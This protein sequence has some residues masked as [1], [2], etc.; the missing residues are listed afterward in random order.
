MTWI[1]QNNLCSPNQERYLLASLAGSH[2]YAL[3]LSFSLPP[4]VDATRL[5]SIA[6]AT[7]GKIPG[8]VVRFESVDLGRFTWR[9]DPS[10]GPAIRRQ[11]APDVATAT[12]DAAAFVHGGK[13]PARG[14]A[15]CKLHLAALE[16]GSHVLTVSLH[17]AVA[18]AVS[19]GLVIDSISQAW[20]TGQIAPPTGSEVSAPHL[21]TAS[22]LD[23]TH[24]RSA[25]ANADDASALLLT[26]LGVTEGAAIRGETSVRLDLPTR[27][28]LTAQARDAGVTTFEAVFAAYLLVLGRQTGRPAAC[29]TFQSSGRRSNPGLDAVVGVFSNALPV[30][31]HPDHEASFAAHARAVRH[32][33]RA[34]LQHEALPYHEIIRETGIH[35]S[36]GINWYPGAEALALDGV[37]IVGDRRAGWQSDFDLNF[38]AL[39]DETGLQMTLSFPTERVA[40]WQAECVVEHVYALIEGGAL[41][42]TAPV[43]ALD[44]PGHIAQPVSS[45]G[46]VTQ[47]DPLAWLSNGDDPK[48]TALVSEGFTLDGAAAAQD[49]ATLA[50]AFQSLASQPT[51]AVAL[52]LPRETVLPVAVEAALTAGLPFACYDP[53]YPEAR[54]TAMDDVLRPALRVR[55]PRPGEEASGEKVTI[56]MLS[57]GPF[58][59]ERTMLPSP[60]APLPKDARYALFTSGTTGRP[61]CIPADGR[62]LARFIDGYVARFGIDA[63][64]RFA[65]L[66]G[67]GHDP[68]L[69]DILAPRRVG[70]A[71]HLPSE[72]I[73]REPAALFDWVVRNRITILHVT[74]Q[75]ARMLTLG[76]AGRLLPDLRLVVFGGDT[77]HCE[78]VEKL[79]TVAPNATMVNLYGATETP[80][81]ASLYELTGGED[82]GSRVCPVGQGAFGRSLGVR[83]DGRVAAIGEPGEIVVLGTDLAFPS[84]VADHEDAGQSRL[85]PDTH[86]SG[87]LGLTL[88]SGD[89]MV[90]GRIDAQVKV[91]G[92]RVEPNEIAASLKTHPKVSQA[93]VLPRT[94]PGGET[95]LIAYAVC[96]EA[97]TGQAL[98][99]HCEK[100]LPSAMAPRAVV[101]LE[102]LPLTSNGKL[103]RAA[104]PDPDAPDEHGL[105]N[106]TATTLASPA[107]RAR[108]EQLVH[109]VARTLGR[110]AVDPEACVSELG[111]DSLSYLRVSLTLEE[112]LGSLPHDWDSV[113]LIALAD[114]MVDE[115]KAP[116]LTERIA[117]VRMIETPVL[118]RAV[119]IAAVVAG[120]FGLIHFGGATSALFFVAGH[121]FGRFQVPAV[122][123][124]DSVRPI[125]S[126]IGVIALPTILYMLLIQTAFATPEPLTFLLVGNF[127]GPDVVKGLSFWFIDVLVQCLALMALLLAIPQVR[128]M[129]RAHPFAGA[130][131]AVL[132]FTLARYA[133]QPFWDTDPLYDRVV[134]EQIWLVALGWMLAQAK[135]RKERIVAIAI[136]I[137]VLT[138][139]FLI[140]GA[141]RPITTAAFLI[142]LSAPRL[143]IPAFLARPITLIA[144][145]SL[146]IYLTHF[147][148]QSVLNKF[149]FPSDS[150]IVAMLFFLAALSCGV[151]VQKMWDFSSNLLWTRLSSFIWRR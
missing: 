12:Q 85:A 44:L 45:T 112:H 21:R 76:A 122:L 128:R 68:M 134:H 102:R 137:A 46:I 103:D 81:A 116:S 75:L 97:I 64:D 126:L 35:P 78:V 32:S 28:A 41:A 11:Q 49:V 100:L 140:N 117:S 59:I 77:L 3:P 108:T 115:A 70:A 99:R 67:L 50:R 62:G 79:R 6:A 36:F 13:D 25:L 18:D 8:L 61:K 71:L 143:P 22:T 1:K 119:A 42:D 55:P 31:A 65:L 88:P 101:V 96:T 139:D 80:Q 57:S 146:F 91:R 93:I 113:P 121:S 69:R 26:R 124:E 86:A 84:Y 132:V 30:V 38:H 106:T 39:N 90:L 105:N 150:D 83:R 149:P 82:W 138:M 118:M 4:E 43:G 5:L 123:R 98:R 92:T 129:L 142:I 7:L 58:A 56:V 17:H 20:N 15:P 66:G 73:R 2:S 40:P 10:R 104:L 48:P 120:H 72:A 111:V 47:E 60:H 23:R 133:I 145:A 148:A 24:W 37:R 89:I 114:R 110:S 144:S 94:L 9:P 147:Q 34:A 74:P 19:L 54:L 127:L 136:A 109:A 131:C 130:I 14:G 52:V 125:F 63:N 27:D 107:I 51:D 29:A 16:D 135:L 87:D 141:L 33:V 53:D 95:E 151:V